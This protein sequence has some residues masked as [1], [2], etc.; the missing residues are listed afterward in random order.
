MHQLY[1]LF[2]LYN[3]LWNRQCRKTGL[4]AQLDLKLSYFV[5]WV[6]YNAMVKMQQGSLK[7]V[8]SSW[9]HTQTVCEHQ[10]SSQI[11]TLWPLYSFV[12]LLWPLHGTIHVFTSFEQIFFTPSAESLWTW[13]LNNNLQ[14]HGQNKK[15][16][17]ILLPIYSV[18]MD[19]YICA[20]FMLNDLHTHKAG[21]IEL[22]TETE[23]NMHNKITNIVLTS[24]PSNSV[25][26]RVHCPVHHQPSG[27]DRRLLHHKYV[28]R[29]YSRCIKKH[30][31]LPPNQ[32]T[33]HRL[34]YVI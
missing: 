34:L 6:L 20:T 27:F 23:E 1:V 4:D 28:F 11:S 18:M 29:M 25:I 24:R 21:K 32:P 13:M 3:H 26:C 16:I 22:R 19:D 30:Y 8:F 33:P 31:W 10:T 12:F 5:L 7:K 9:A 2:G 17:E 15:K 14:C